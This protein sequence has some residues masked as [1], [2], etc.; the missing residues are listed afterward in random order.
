M[1]NKI[2]SAVII[3]VFTVFSAGHSAVSDILERGIRRYLRGDYTEAITDFERVLEIE[4]NPRARRLLYNSYLEEGK[5]HLERERQS[6][7]LEYFRK[8]L[9]ADPEGEEAREL[10]DAVEAEVSPPRP[11]APDPAPELRELREQLSAQRSAN[12]SLRNQINRLTAQRDTLQQELSSVQ[13]EIE[14]YSA[15]IEALR[16]RGERSGRILL[17]GLSGGGVL[18]LLVG[19]LIFRALR[20]LSDTSYEGQYQ[21]EELEEKIAA[22][23]KE[24]EEQSGELEERVA[25]SINKMIDGQREAVK[26]VSFSASGQAKKD[27]EE[28][29]DRLEGQF[30][31]NQ[32]RLLE[33]LNMQAKALAGEKTE[34][35]ELKGKDGRMVITDVN[36]HVRARADGVEMIPKTIS[37]PNIAEKMLKPYLSDPNNRVRANACVA[38]YRY[39]Q[40]ASLTVLKRMAEHSDKWMRASA[41]WAAG[42]IGTP[43]TVPVIRKLIEDVEERVRDRAVKAFESMAELKEDIGGEIRRMIE[44]QKRKK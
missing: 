26:Q 32:N 16:D 38:I 24:A 5:A 10:I 35:I 28:I 3:L 9:E 36:P 17:Y 41:A 27:L 13:G 18:F 21:I 14:E 43:E 44:A 25:R 34:K 2:Y 42:E 7:A 37:D 23:L 20:R 11:A 39:N 4:D 31:E 40:E 33:L 12:A 8:A 1:R 15:Q 29:K 30:E 6:R 19:F 22:R